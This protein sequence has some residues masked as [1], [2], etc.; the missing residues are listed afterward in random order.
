MSK[1]RTTGKIFIIILLVFILSGCM[2]Q[3]EVDQLAYVVAIG[4]GKSEEDDNL[5]K[6]TYIFANPESG[7]QAGGSGGDEPPQE[8]I[9]FSATD[10]ITS[11]SLANAV[12]A[13]QVTYDLLRLIIVSE[14]FAK[15][16]DFIRW[17]YD[18]TKAMEIRRDIRLLVSQ[19]EPSVF[20]Q[21]NQPKLD[22]RP[23]QYFE[24]MFNRG[25][26]TGTVPPSKLNRFFRITEADANLF[27]SIYATTELNDDT[28]ENK[29]PDNIAAGEF[30]FE[31][32]TNNTQFAGSA[33]FKEGIMID[34]LTIEETRLAFLLSNVLQ[35]PDEILTSLP[36][37]F[38]DEHYLT[39]RIRRES[40]VDLKMNLD[41]TKPSILATIP[42][43]IEVMTNH[44]MTDFTD[45]E[46]I[47]QTLEKSFEDTLTE[48]FDELIKKTQEKYSTEP[49]GW[50]LVARK[51]FLTIPEWESFDWMKTYPNMEIHTDVR[52][53]LEKF[54]RQTELPSLDEMRD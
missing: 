48:K 49:F 52:V 19:E 45:S 10:F 44:G 4:L 5:V 32:E 9:S 8:T 27:L 13:K 29:D 30:E 6:I 35:Q 7:T 41:K 40:N 17:I 34:T 12:I 42:I 22:T 53:D 46:K 54:G 1:L 20:V 18:A 23:H 14:D 28:K 50:S 31:G 51:E 38:T 2:D 3:T 36:D 47:R 11:R 37:P 26:N 21:N 33:V 43:S 15:D 39:V 25:L 16:E 24:L